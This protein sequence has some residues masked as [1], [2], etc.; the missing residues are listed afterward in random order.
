V[1]VRA[2]LGENLRRLRT[3]AGLTQEQLGIKVDMNMSE[4]SRVERGKNDPRL[5]TMVR[6]AAGLDLTLEQL[7]AGMAKPD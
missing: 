6:L 4:I 7:V 5:T 3:E 2:Q 1:D